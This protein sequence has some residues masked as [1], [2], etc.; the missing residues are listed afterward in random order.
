M[1]YS[2]GV[3]HSNLILDT[4]VRSILQVFNTVF[5]E[6]QS[7]VDALIAVSSPY[8]LQFASE[9]KLCFIV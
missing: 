3:R 6:F 1:N 4:S 7:S 5:T 2:V 9:L 8:L